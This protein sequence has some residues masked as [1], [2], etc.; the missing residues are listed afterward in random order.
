MKP[1]IYPKPRTT[2][3]TI[4]I[5]ATTLKLT[6]QVMALRNMNIQKK[7]HL[8]VERSGHQ[9]YCP[10]ASVLTQV[11]IPDILVENVF[12]TTKVEINNMP[13][14]TKHEHAASATFA[15]GLAYI[16]ITSFYYSATYLT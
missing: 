12:S 13:C 9:H 7:I 4:Q 6:Q 14:D 2:G 5:L 15:P 8:K 11:S 16:I 1:L 3:T 10:S